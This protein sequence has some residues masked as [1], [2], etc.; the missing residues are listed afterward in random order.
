[1]SEELV[2]RRKRLKFRA[3]H[4]GT[5][6]TDL[7]IGRFADSHLDHFDTADLDRFEALI[8]VPD[9]VLFDWLTGRAEPTPEFDH[10]VFRQMAAF[11]QTPVGQTP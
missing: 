1:M 6:E 11:V 7:M 3:W 2:V 5:R 8:E 4:R 9:L 10:A